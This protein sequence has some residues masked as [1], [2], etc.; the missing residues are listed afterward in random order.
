MILSIGN[1]IH[2]DLCEAHLRDADARISV[3]AVAT[4]AD[5][6]VGKAVQL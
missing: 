4:G 2:L 1:R 6:V 3:A 5:V